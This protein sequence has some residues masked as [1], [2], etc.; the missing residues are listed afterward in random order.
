MRQ[1]TLK[2]RNEKYTIIAQDLNSAMRFRVGLWC[3]LILALQ[4]RD[5]DF[6]IMWKQ[7]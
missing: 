2:Q 1:L 4:H 3:Q 6:A 7:H 5:I